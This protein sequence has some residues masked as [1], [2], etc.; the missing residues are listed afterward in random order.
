MRELDLQVQSTINRS[1]GW[2]DR[3]RILIFSNVTDSL[4]SIEKRTARFF[5]SAFHLQPTELEAEHNNIMREYKKIIEDS[6]STDDN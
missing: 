2:I 3:A 6:G 1:F 4:D 5:Q